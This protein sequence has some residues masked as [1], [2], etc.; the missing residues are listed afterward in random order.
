MSV[1]PFTPQFSVQARSRAQRRRRIIYRHSSARICS[2]QLPTQRTIRVLDFAR[3][4][5]KL[6]YGSNQARDLSQSLH[7]AMGWGDR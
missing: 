2:F 7:T 5:G 6:P 4:A 1:K 3:R